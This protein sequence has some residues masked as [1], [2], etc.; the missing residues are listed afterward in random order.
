MQFIKIHDKQFEILINEEKI[1]NR[2]SELAIEISKKYADK[3]PLFVSILNGAFIFA[4]DI[5]RMFKFPC[6]IS[7]IKVSS[8]K[9]VEST[10]KI[11]LL[12]G[13]NENIEGRHVVILEDIIDT[14]IT[15]DFILKEFE[16][17]NPVS[18]EICS[19][20]TK[21]DALKVNIC[22]KYIGF[23]VGNKFLVGYGMDYDGHGRNL[24]AIYKEFSA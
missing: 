15:I 22:S 13:L 23:E 3:N 17:Q 12:F 11:N 8:Y 14:G 21:P 24:N 6:E 16:K 9:G 2:V 5:F 20:I 4:S 10:G 1:K 19:F 7:F 18:V